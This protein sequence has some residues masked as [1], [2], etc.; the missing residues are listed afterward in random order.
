MVYKHGGLE[1][2]TMQVPV[3]EFP[4]VLCLFSSMS[5]TRPLSFVWLKRSCLVFSKESLPPV[6]LW[7]CLLSL[8]LEVLAVELADESLAG[9]FLL[10]CSFSVKLYPLWQP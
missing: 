1:S 6:R 10:F 3:T 9:L 7:D 4:V 5:L 8:L 2:F